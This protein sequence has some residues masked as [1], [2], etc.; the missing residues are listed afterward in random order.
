MESDDD[1]KYK[2]RSVLTWF[3]R[4]LRSRQTTHRR[5]TSIN[6]RTEISRTRWT[7]Y[8]ILLIL[9]VFLSILTILYHLTRGDDNEQ[10]DR[11]NDPQFNPLNNPFIRVGGRFLKNPVKDSSSFLNQEQLQ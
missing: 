6:S 7:I 4:W 10:F 9:F 5:G 2:R 8:M 1:D 11:I 3:A